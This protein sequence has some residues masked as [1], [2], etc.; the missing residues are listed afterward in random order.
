M[1]NLGKKS[2]I[3][4]VVSGLITLSACKKESETKVEETTP[5]EETTS[6]EETQ[7]VD[8]AVK[9]EDQGSEEMVKIENV[10]DL[11][12]DAVAVKEV[13]DKVTVYLTKVKRLGQIL[14]V[15]LQTDMSWSHMNLK[16][17]DINYIDDSTSKVYGV[18]K[19][20]ADKY[21]ATPIHTQGKY[22]QITDGTIS[23]LKFP[24]PPAG[25]KTITITFP[26]VGTFNEVEIQE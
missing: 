11:Q 18:L 6:V 1:K 20:D 10:A 25:S 23:E 22:L 3:L 13:N 2:L 21:M 19:D 12:K 8:D 17:D 15:E 9:V 7:E 4:C 24:A 14:L 16:I 5:V 26:E